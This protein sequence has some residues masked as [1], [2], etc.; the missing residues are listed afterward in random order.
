MIHPAIFFPQNRDTPCQTFD[1]A[2][3]LRPILAAIPQPARS[4]VLLVHPWRG[5]DPDG[6]HR[7]GTF[8]PA[9]DTPVSAFMD[10]L[11]AVS[12][13]LREL[14]ATA[15]LYTGARGEL[16]NPNRR[17]QWWDLYRAR[18]AGVYLDNLGA[19]YPGSLEMNTA[20]QGFALGTAAKPACVGGE[21][22]GGSMGG[23]IARYRAR[24][25]VVAQSFN[26]NGVR[27]QQE[28]RLSPATIHGYGAVAAGLV[29]SAYTKVDQQYFNT[30]PADYAAWRCATALDL[31]NVFDLDLVWVRAGGITGA[32]WALLGAAA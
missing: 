30:H 21:A 7:E 22:N 32:Q 9:P 17:R 3:D 10:Q 13:V 26:W 31:I 4:R 20:V 25:H 27:P 16:G 18:F 5:I 29:W 11:A 8:D 15:Y 24:A 23:V 28:T 12:D 19:F 6:S 14:G 1:L 2:G